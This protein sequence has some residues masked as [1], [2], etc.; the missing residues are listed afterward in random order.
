MLSVGIDVGGTKCLAVGLSDKGERVG[1]SVEPT[2]SGLGIVDQLVEVMRHFPGATSLGIGMPGIVGKDGTV[3][4]APH[5]PEV[6]NLPLQHL[7]EDRL[8]LP[9]FIDNDA[10][11][12]AIAEWRVGVARGLNDVLVVTIGTGIGG[13]IIAGGRVVRGAH[14]FAGEIGHHV[15]VS[16]GEHCPCGRSGCWEQYAS[17]NALRRMASGV[18]G[19]EVISRVSEGDAESLRI[20]RESAHWIALGL[21]NLI[22]TLDPECVVLGGGLGSSPV[23]LPLVDTALDAMMPSSL[24]RSR[25]RLCAAQLG[26]EAGAIGAAY[27]GRGD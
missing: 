1:T 8:S 22:N 25:P 27:L 17:G 21:F 19:E 15:V 16:G 4:L 7:L 9:V 11:C 23:L 26:H 24:H 6:R 13:G 12:A 3:H 20:L 18:P 5:L 10:T 14:G 2:A